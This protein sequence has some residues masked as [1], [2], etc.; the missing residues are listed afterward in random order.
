[1]IGHVEVGF[2][3]VW[4]TVCDTEGDTRDAHVVCRLLGYDKGLIATINSAFGKGVGY[5]WGEVLDCGVDP[6][7]TRI[8]DCIFSIPSASESCL[9]H[10]ED[11]GVVC[12][13]A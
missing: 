9:N 13:G 6:E 7:E 11:L 12:T 10:A 2:H 8:E 1:M 5:V 3:G 4:G